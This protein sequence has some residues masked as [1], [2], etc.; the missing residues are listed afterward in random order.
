[1]LIVTRKS[2]TALVGTD[3]HGRHQF[4][5]VV[6]RTSRGQVRIGIRAHHGIRIQREEDLVSSGAENPPA[7][8]T[9]GATSHEA[10]QQA[11]SDN[12]PPSA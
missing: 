3:E 4:T 11:F 9:T 2:G 5:V 12:E 8:G 7:D 1:M 6:L 10:R